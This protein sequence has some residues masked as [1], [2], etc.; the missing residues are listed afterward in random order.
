MVPLERSGTWSAKRMQ[1]RTRTWF[2]SSRA[3]VA[4]GTLLFGSTATAV[5]PSTDGVTDSVVN[6]PAS[7]PASE[8]D[9]L[10]DT[11]APPAPETKKSVP[12]MST[13][14][15]FYLAAASGF[16]MPI[17]RGPYEGV[18]EPYDGTETVRSPGVNL[19]VA[20]GGAPRPGLIVGFALDTNLGPAR[21]TDDYTGQGL[22]DGVTK[23]SGA[24]YAIGTSVFVQG[25][26]RNF[27]LRGGVGGMG[28]FFIDGDSSDHNE[29]TGGVGF[30]LAL[31]A[32]FP[33][34]HKAAVGFSAG[35]RSAFWGYDDD[36][37][38]GKIAIVQPL[39]R[40]EVVVF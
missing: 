14:R 2:C 8:H 37:Y 30:D 25:Y 5:E 1:T 27:F 40:F 23:R 4:T 12:P 31:G 29:L 3:L 7:E 32:H 15:G 39:L 38:R 16:G 6:E 24:G 17:H 18:G 33:V 20:I 28:L 11:K 21:Y 10:G 13:R 19:G 35:L 9:P 34:A 36:D 26:I 22:P